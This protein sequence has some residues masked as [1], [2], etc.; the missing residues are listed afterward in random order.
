MAGLILHFAES[1]AAEPADV[2]SPSLACVLDVIAGSLVGIFDEQLVRGI[3][4]QSIY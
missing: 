3:A 1:H 4:P 2:F